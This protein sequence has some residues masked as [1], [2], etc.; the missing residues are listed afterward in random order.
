MPETLRLFVS[1]THDLEAERAVIGRAIA[2]L[3]F[4]DAVVQPHGVT[5]GVGHGWLQETIGWVCYSRGG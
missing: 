3:Q 5:R 1:A 4:A 2:R